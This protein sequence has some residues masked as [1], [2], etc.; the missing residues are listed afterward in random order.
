M[1]R[2]EKFVESYVISWCIDGIKILLML[3]VGVILP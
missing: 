1:Q 3:K 2:Y